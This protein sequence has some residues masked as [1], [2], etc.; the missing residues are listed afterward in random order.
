MSDIFHGESYVVI[1]KDDQGY[2]TLVT[3]QAFPNRRAALA[4]L[5]T[6]AKSREPLFVSGLWDQI[7]FG[8]PEKLWVWHDRRKLDRQMTREEAAQYGKEHMPPEYKAV[9]CKVAISEHRHH[10]GDWFEI[11]YIEPTD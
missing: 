5:D 8:A 3:R 6:L 1:C 4:Y 11:E 7:R 2:Y 10:N 9:F